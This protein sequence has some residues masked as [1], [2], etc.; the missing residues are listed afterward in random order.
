MKNLNLDIISIKRVVFSKKIKFVVLPGELGDL[1]ILPGHIP[2]ISN[3]RPGIIK[4]IHI[5]DNEENIFIMGGILEIKQTNVTVLSDTTI[6]ERDLD[7]SE[8]IIAHKKMKYAL[9][10]TQSKS[11]IAIIEAELAILTAQI[12]AARKFVRKNISY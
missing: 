6:H 10:N 5:N 9:N 4:I 3:I 1:G 7:E 11:D 12:N 8:I 2:L